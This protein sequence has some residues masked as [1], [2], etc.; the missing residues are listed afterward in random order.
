MKS[1]KK[2]KRNRLRTAFIAVFLVIAVVCLAAGGLLAGVLYG[3]YKKTP[4][5]DLEDIQIKVATTYI[6]DDEGNEIVQ[7][8]PAM[9]LSSG[10]RF[11]IRTSPNTWGRRSLLLKTNGSKVISVLTFLGISARSIFEN[12]CTPADLC[13]AQAL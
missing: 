2:V 4:P 8:S 3:Y 6:Y 7:S 11:S 13:M 12:P 1:R 9:S 5:L 10:S